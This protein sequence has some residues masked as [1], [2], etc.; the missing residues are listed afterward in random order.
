MPPVRQGAEASFLTEMPSHAYTPQQQQEMPVLPTI[1][2][3]DVATI[4][5]SRRLCSSYSEP[6]NGGSRYWSRAEW[7]S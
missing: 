1:D 6:A 3:R 4:G 2:M 7:S 5:K